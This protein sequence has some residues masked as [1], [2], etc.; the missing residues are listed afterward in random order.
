MVRIYLGLLLVCVGLS[1]AFSASLTPPDSLVTRPVRQAISLQI[2]TTGPGVFYNREVSSLH[3]LT[4]RVGGQYF[5]YRKSIQVKA[6]S[7]SY[8]QIKPDVTIGMAQAALK[9]HP[10][11]RSSFFLTGGV[12]YTWHPDMRFVITAENTLNFDGL[13]LTPQDVGTVNLGFRWHPVVGYLGWG[14]GR[15]LPDKRLGVGVEMGVF[16]L[17]KP[18]VSLDYE[19]FLETTTIDDQVAVVEK[20]LSG[21]RYLPT[22]NLTLS[23][24]ISH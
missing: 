8:V 9:W 4:L 18:R 3:R 10:F 1:N 23:Y 21:Y 11:R 6:A 2:G 22:I 13:E 7:D 14:F 15:S 5:A 17:G 12:G 20:N 16:Y 19:G 24:K